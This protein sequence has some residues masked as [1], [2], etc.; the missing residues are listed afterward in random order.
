MFSLYGLIWVRDCG[1]R[2]M[3]LVLLG[4]FIF[5]SHLKKKKKKSEN[6]TQSCISFWTIH[7]PD[8]KKYS[9]TTNNSKHKNGTYYHSQID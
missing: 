8:V 1:R 9:T 2:H 4:C 7:D 3:C 6:E 5:P